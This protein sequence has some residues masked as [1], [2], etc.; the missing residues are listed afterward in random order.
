MP[1]YHDPKTGRWKACRLSPTRLASLYDDPITVAYGVDTGEFV[2]DWRKQDLRDGCPYC[3]A[4]AVENGSEPDVLR[5]W[6]LI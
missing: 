4:D 5:R 6:G 1:T 2:N 3:L